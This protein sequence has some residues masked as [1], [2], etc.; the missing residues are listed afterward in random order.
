MNPIIVY[1]KMTFEKTS[2]IV[3]L[4]TWWPVVKMSAPIFG[5]AGLTLLVCFLDILTGIVISAAI[6]F[7]GFA[8]MA[9]PIYPKLRSKK[10][11]AAINDI[12]ETL[13]LTFEENKFS[14]QSLRRNENLSEPEFFE[15]ANMKCREKQGKFY[16]KESDKYLSIFDAS[17][18]VQ[19]DA[20]QFRKLLKEKS[21]KLQ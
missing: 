18:I 16:I 10:Y 2:K 4:S 3:M 5:I 15:Y 14:I 1:S 19:G 6:A 8:V 9:F 21:I 11:K 12:D 17:E 20:I 13:V 7:F